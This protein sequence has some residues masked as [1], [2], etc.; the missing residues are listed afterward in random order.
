LEGQETSAAP[1]TETAPVKMSL[2]EAVKAAFRTPA[3]PETKIDDAS[4]AQEAADDAADNDPMAPLP[5]ATDQPSE[6]ESSASS[7]GTHSKADAKPA[8]DA[9]AAP[10]PAKGSL[11]APR[12]WK[13]EWREKFEKL[14]PE[15]KEILLERDREY[16]KGFTKNAQEHAEVRR[17]SEGVKSAFQPHH[18][19]QMAQTGLDDVGAVKYLLAQHDAF[20][21][22]PVGFVA[23]T[24]KQVGDPLK[25]L[26]AVAQRAGVSLD[27][28]ASQ[29]AQAQPAQAA[30]AA[31][32]VDPQVIELRK[33]LDETRQ[34]LGGITQYL[35]TQTQT[36][37]QREATMREAQE[38]QW[39]GRVATE[40]ENFVGATDD[41][42]NLLYP[43]AEDVQQQ[44]AVLLAS[45]P[46]LAKLKYSDPARALQE[47][48]QHA[49]YLNPQ[50]RESVIEAEKARA[51][52]AKEAEWRQQFQTAQAAQAAH[53]AK[54]AATVKG[55]PGAN[56]SSRPQQRMSIDEA[57]RAGVRSVFR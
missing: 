2:D 47:A 11:E 44:M 42:G 35:Q 39:Q 17:F 16:N 7:D 53:R 13:K 5:S 12:Q 40:I 32:W 27:A 9:K 46:T 3:P 23:T 24:A 8:P 31:E 15:A 21:S 48:Y 34:Q 4:T 51:L 19:Q 29:A 52:A 26:S 10:E 6:N 37:A 20:N 38:R 56:G 36:A 54:T 33:Q 30:D 45:E 49:V 43:H 41:Q 50:I 25:F 14:T 28:S 18:R 1:V 55:S 57:V 22:D